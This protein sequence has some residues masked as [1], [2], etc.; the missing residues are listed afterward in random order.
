MEASHS[1]P[2]GTKEDS[3]MT[4]D[5]LPSYPSLHPEDGGR[6]AFQNNGIP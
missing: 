1:N 6:M 3:L 5:L 2:K 4:N